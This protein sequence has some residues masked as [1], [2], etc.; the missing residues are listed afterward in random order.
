M[1]RRDITGQVFGRLTALRF[2]ERRG[3]QSYWR[4]QCEC[5]KEHVAYLGHVTRGKTQSCGCFGREVSVQNGKKKVTHGLWEYMA[6]AHP[7]E[8]IIAGVG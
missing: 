7:H 5:G 1:P 3:E 8:S 6:G 2:E 4:F